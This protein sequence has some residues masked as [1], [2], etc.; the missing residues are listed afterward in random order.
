MIIKI[1]PKNSESNRN[2]IHDALQ[3]HKIKNKTECT[4][5]FEIKT[6]ILLNINNEVKKECKKIII[7]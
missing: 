1:S 2:K 4:G 7:K 5:F 3:K 6:K